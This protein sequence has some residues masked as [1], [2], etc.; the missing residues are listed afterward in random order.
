V[1]PR[2][3]GLRVVEVLVDRADLRPL[4]A[5]LAA[6]VRDAVG[7]VVGSEIDG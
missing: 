6:A 7:P 3:Q 1:T 2:P 5:A 4:H